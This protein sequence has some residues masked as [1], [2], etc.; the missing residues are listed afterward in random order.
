MAADIAIVPASP[1]GLDVNRIM[2]T[3]DL[4]AEVE[5]VHAVVC[6]VL[7]TKA[8]RGTV[9]ARSVRDVL[10]EA[11]LPVLDTEI[12]LSEAYASSF[13]IAPTDLGAYDDLIQ[14][15]KS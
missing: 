1:T 12:P 6:G 15:L 14:E 11:G 9:S 3:V 2:P 7:I 5:P 4:L 10:A 13:G 8:R